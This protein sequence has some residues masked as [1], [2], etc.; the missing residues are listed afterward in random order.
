[1]NS[2]T[3]QL[4]GACLTQFYGRAA[5][6]RRT[7]KLV[8]CLNKQFSAPSQFVRLAQRSCVDTGY[9]NAARGATRIEATR[10]PERSRNETQHLP[11]FGAGP[12]GCRN[13]DDA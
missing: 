2:Q 12:G 8:S 6:L 3:G 13:H 4:T 7:R 11:D 5:A 9:K 10:L 1:M